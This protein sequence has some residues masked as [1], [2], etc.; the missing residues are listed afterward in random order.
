MKLFVCITTIPPR[1]HQLPNVINAFLNNTVKP[2]K[3]YI[4]ICKKYLR[5]NTSY[6][7]SYLD[8]FVNNN[9][10]HIH[11]IEQDIGSVTKLM[12]PLDII[13]KE[14]DNHEDIYL[15]TTDDDLLPTPQFVSKYLSCIS[16]DNLVSYTGYNENI[17]IFNVGFCG[18]GLTFRLSNMHKFNEYC[19]LLIEHNNKWRFH[20][21]L[22]FSSFLHLNNIKI[23]RTGTAMRD[24]GSYTIVDKHSITYYTQT[25]QRDLR[26]IKRNKELSESYKTLLDNGSLEKFKLNL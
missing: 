5:F 26:G 8:K 2:D 11:V 10:V 25:K 22:L 23:K 3:I 13:L 4:T 24:P 17:H 9:I 21:D 20:D 19:F 16:N 12:G 7:M 15:V 1:A 14:N 18:D 6:N